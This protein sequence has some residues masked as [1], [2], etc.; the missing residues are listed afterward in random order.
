MQWLLI[1]KQE[2]CLEGK[3]TVLW[4]KCYTAVLRTRSKPVAV[5]IITTVVY[6][7]LYDTPIAVAVQRPYII[8]AACTI[9]GK[10]TNKGGSCFHHTTPLFV[11][12]AKSP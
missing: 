5:V 10:V 2:V 1:C 8:F 9:Q 3:S 7:Y 4:Q 11:Y 12:I 6:L